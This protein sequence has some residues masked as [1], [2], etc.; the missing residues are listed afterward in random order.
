MIAGLYLIIHVSIAPKCIVISAND[1]V[2]R[3]PMPF[4]AIDYDNDLYSTIDSIR[5]WIIHHK[6]NMLTNHGDYNK[7]SAQPI[8]L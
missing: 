2:F 7:E 3:Y 6:E 8:L 4:A 1:I 5:V